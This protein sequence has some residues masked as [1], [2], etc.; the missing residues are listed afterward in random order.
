MSP[1]P[2]QTKQFL[3]L[4]PVPVLKLISNAAIHASHGKIH[5]S[6]ANKKLF[7]KNSKIFQTLLNKN[8]GFEK[9]RLALVNQR[10]GG[11]FIPT[12]IATVLSAIGPA[13]FGLL[14][15]NE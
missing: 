15:K 9:K 1:S 6:D 4:A 2:H 13:L 10:G 12:L 14:K 11:F 3:S 8:L 7:R 5:L